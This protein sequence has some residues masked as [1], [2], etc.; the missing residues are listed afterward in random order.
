MSAEWED[1]SSTGKSQYLQISKGILQEGN[2]RKQDWPNWSLEHQKHPERCSVCHHPCD[3]IK[4]DLRVPSS[5]RL[6]QC[7]GVDSRKAIILSFTEKTNFTMTFKPP[8]ALAKYRLA[9]S[10]AMD[11]SCCLPKPQ[12]ACGNAVTKSTS[13]CHKHQNMF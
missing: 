3:Q 13:V 2:T 4:A 12:S 6:R 11:D 10:V 5:L 7:L 8:C 1:I 9:L